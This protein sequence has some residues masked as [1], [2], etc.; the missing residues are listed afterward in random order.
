VAWGITE[1]IADLGFPGQAIEVIICEITKTRCGVGGEPN[2]EEL[3][4]ISLSK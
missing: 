3:K 2:S 1:I 4:K